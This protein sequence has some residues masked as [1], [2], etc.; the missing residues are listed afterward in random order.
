MAIIPVDKQEPAEIGERVEDI[1]HGLIL[2]KLLSRLYVF[3]PLSSSYNFTRTA[4]TPAA[5]EYLEGLILRNRR[6]Y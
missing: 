1:I 5:M 6:E 4:T 2:L 3:F